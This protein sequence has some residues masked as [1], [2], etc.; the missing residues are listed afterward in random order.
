M[1]FY[2]IEL[3]AGTL[4]KDLTVEG[5]TIFP[6]TNLQKGRM[7]FNTS[8]NSLFCYDGTSWIS[9]SGAGVTSFNNR[10]GA[11]TLQATDLV[12]R[13]NDTNLPIAGLSK[14]GA[15]KVGDGLTIDGGGVL[16]I[17]TTSTV[18][19]PP[20]SRLL[21]AQ[22]AAP[23][24][25]TQLSTAETNDRLLRV[26][27]AVGGTPG[28][29]G[30]GGYGYGGLDSPILNNKIPTHTHS[31]SATTNTTGEHTHTYT[32]LLATQ[33]QSGS[34]TPC[35]WGYATGNTSAAGSHSHTASGTTNANSG[36]DTWQPKYLNLIL[37]S[38]D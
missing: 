4:V 20:R 38:K 9:A 19:I 3:A 33:P 16:S 34:A 29:G 32:H 35:W 7:F 15:I 2:G 30:T 21:W 36:A 11:V 28:T 23:T 26:V 12:G 8:S 17:A 5:G 18:D 10:V 27:S 24:G 25:W 37:C 31:F 13:L 6:S 1:I 14:L 22:P